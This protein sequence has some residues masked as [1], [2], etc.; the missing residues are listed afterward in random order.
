MVVRFQKQRKKIIV[1]VWFRMRMKWKLIN[2]PF[3]CEIL[4]VNLAAG[5]LVFLYIRFYADTKLRSFIFS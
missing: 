5:R 3:R 2:T 1:Q 4:Q